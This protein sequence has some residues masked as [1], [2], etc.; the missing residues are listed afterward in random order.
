MTRV[1][2]EFPIEEA[3]SIVK[4]LR[5]DPMSAAHCD[6]AT[7]GCER[8][9][10]AISIERGPGGAHERDLHGEA[11]ALVGSEVCIRTTYGAE[12]RGYLDRVRDFA[13]V[14]L[15]TGPNAR[16]PIPLA[17]VVSIEPESTEGVAA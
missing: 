15:E 8:I 3:E 9:E 16:Q 10:R 5:E 2:V 6:A 17:Q 12:K 13:T 4:R 11:C 1:A 14:I 7:A